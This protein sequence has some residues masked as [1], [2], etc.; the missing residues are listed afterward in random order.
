MLVSPLMGPVL[1]VTFGITIRNPK[2]AKF[3]LKNELISLAVCVVVGF[4][5]GFGWAL[6]TNNHNDWPTQEMM[7]RGK[8]PWAITDGLYIA[9]VSGIGVALSVLGEYVST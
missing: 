9:A 5:V 1:A 4:V 7:N 6:G 3:G 8:W 2:L